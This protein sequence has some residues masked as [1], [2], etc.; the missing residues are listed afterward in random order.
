MVSKC[1]IPHHPEHIE[2]AK[3]VPSNPHDSF[4]PDTVTFTVPIL[5]AILTWQKDTMEKA[6]L[7]WHH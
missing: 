4:Y 3:L 6:V 2:K 7:T 1:P 5:L